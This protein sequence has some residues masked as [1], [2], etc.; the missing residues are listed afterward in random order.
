M[1][2]IE[3]SDSEQDFQRDVAASGFDNP[4]PVHVL[5][6]PLVDHCDVLGTDKIGFVQHDQVR[7][8]D[9]TQLE[10]IQGLIVASEKIDSASM[11]Q[12]MLSSRKSSSY[13]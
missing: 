8:A 9:L 7:K 6:N 13:L 2:R 4:Y 1:C 10:H 11:M 5:A 12:V 3:A